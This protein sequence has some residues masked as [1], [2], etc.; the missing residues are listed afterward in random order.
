MSKDSFQQRTKNKGIFLHIPDTTPKPSIKTSHIM[1]HLNIGGI[2]IYTR[3]GKTNS[4][5]QLLHK[6]D[7]VNFL[8]DNQ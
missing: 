3:T 8:I 6:N 7:T 1:N 5:S 2:S 4:Y